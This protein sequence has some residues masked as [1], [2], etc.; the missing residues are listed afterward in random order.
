MGSWSLTERV[1]ATVD[2]AEEP[3]EEQDVGSLDGGVEE[4]EDATPYPQGKSRI[5]GSALLLPTTTITRFAKHLYPRRST[6]KARF[7]PSKQMRKRTGAT[8]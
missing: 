1:E 4:E 7:I 8:S 6:A 3:P 2:P 5:I